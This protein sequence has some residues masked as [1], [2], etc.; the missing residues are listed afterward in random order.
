VTDWRYNPGGSAN[1]R[2]SLDN[3]NDKRRKKTTMKRSIRSSEKK[4]KSMM[5][6]EARVITPPE[7]VR[8]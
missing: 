2:M 3:E 4:S 1:T 7:S 5:I 6:E 8:L